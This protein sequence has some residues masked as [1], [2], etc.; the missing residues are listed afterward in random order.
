[1]QLLRKKH[2]AT[3]LTISDHPVTKEVNTALERQ[4]NFMTM[5]ELALDTA[6][7]LMG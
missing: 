3:L 5:V 2:A 6:I 1:M 7:Q 4:N